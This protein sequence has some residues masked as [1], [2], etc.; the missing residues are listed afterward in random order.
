MLRGPTVI[1]AAALALAVLGAP[2]CSSD[3]RDEVRKTG[4]DVSTDL[5]STI[6]DLS[7]DVSSVSGTVS[8]G[9]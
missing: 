4:S 5:S 1:A 9:G 2:A 8:S 7:S 6:S 3:P